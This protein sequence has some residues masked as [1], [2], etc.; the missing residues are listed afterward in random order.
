MSKSAGDRQVRQPLRSRTTGLPR[1]LWIAPSFEDLVGVRYHP[2]EVDVIVHHSTEQWS[3]VER[4]DNPAR[5]KPFIVPSAE[6]KP[7]RANART[8]LMIDAP[9]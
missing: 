7:W 4:F 6:L 1:A 5:E 9:L 8:Q 2:A 3:M